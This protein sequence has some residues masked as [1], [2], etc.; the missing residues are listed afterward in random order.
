MLDSFPFSPVDLKYAIR[1]Q[2]LEV[3]YKGQLRR[4]TVA[5]ISRVKTDKDPVEP[6]YAVEFFI[7]GNDTTVSL[8][9]DT[10][11]AIT[12][13]RRR[14]GSRHES[15][16]EAIGGLDAQIAQIRELVEL[17]LTRPD[18][19]AHFGLSHCA[20][21]FMYF[22]LITFSQASLLL[23]VFSCTAR[24]GQERRSLPHASLARSVY[25][26]SR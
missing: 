8:V 19:Y 2:I 23:A 25:H 18:L 24:L 13:A 9:R 6:R 12:K 15:G 7:V 5:R 20:Q 4:L 26:S 14:P 3:N 17:P 11:S 1:G 16:Y 21:Y 22:S 10:P